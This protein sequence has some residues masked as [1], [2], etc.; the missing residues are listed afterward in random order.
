MCDWACLY[1]LV[2][3]QESFCVAFGACLIILT[4]IASAQAPSAHEAK[5]VEP[6]GTFI[7]TGA[8]LRNERTHTR[9]AESFIGRTARLA[10]M[11]ATQC[12]FQVEFILE[13]HQ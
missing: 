13:D 5:S 7:H 6:Y 3:M 11:V 8:L 4:R 1:A 12:R 2:L 10:V 9:S